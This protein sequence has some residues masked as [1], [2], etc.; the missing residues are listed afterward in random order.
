MTVRTFFLAREVFGHVEAEDGRNNVRDQ[1]VE[2]FGNV[3]CALASSVCRGQCNVEFHGNATSCAAA[4]LLPHQ[5]AAQL[6][7]KSGAASLS[8]RIMRLSLQSAA[9]A[10]EK[11][12]W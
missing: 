3:L 5:R 10:V 12:R 4:L 9:K 11:V 2:E 6:S 1:Q 8:A 7:L